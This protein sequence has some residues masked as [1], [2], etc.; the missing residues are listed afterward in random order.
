MVQ[1]ATAVKAETKGRMEIQIFPNSTLGSTTAMLEQMRLGSIQFFSTL[2][3]NYSGVVPVA[4]INSVGFAFTSQRQ[5]GQ[6][7]DGELGGYVRRE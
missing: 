2:D 5:P 7:V 4:A 6:V 3:A 1:L